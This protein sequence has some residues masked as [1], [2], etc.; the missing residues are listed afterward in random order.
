MPRRFAAADIGSNT[1]HL[2]VAEPTS[3]GNLR[4]LVN[5]SEWLSLGEIVAG[6]GE[7]PPQDSLRLIETL[8]RYKKISDEFG[9]E[10]L[11]VFATEAVRIASNHEALLRRIQKTLG[12]S[13]DL[14]SGSRE[15]E[16]SFLGVTLDTPVEGNTVL[17]EVG[18]GSAQVASC[19]G[20]K[21]IEERS[22]PIGTGRCIAK[23]QL[24]NPCPPDTVQALREHV[25]QFWS[26]CP[27]PESLDAMVASGGV[28][29]GLI[30]A[31]HPDGDRVVHLFELEYLIRVV[32]TLSVPAIAKRFGVKSKRAGSLLPGAIVFEEMLRRY[33]QDRFTVSEYGVREGAILEMAKV[34]VAS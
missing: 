3:R 4:R 33:G 21:I 15:A 13:V 12:I 34:G 16:L 18:G 8:R 25:Q 2:L 1:V 22:L 5:E 24:T 6:A 14:I 17:V 9:A 28:A 30:R 32:A 7:I 20:Q 31:L 10:K 26:E 23:F 19:R 27:E 29:R 11:Y